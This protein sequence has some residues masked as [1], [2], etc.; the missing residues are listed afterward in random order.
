MGLRWKD[1]SYA[2]R[3][4]SD[5]EPEDMPP[6]A[7]ENARCKRTGRFLVEKKCNLVKRLSALARRF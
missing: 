1:P 2:R 7:Y 6:A 4:I 5:N 3:E